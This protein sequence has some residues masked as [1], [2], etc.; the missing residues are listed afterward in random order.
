MEGREEEKVKKCKEGKKW[1]GRVKMRRKRREKK[2]KK[3]S[4]SKETGGG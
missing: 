3:R 4:G 2:R 1:T